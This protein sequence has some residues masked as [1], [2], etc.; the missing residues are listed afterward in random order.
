MTDAAVAGL[1]LPTSVPPAATNVSKVQ[2]PELDLA[3]PIESLQEQSSFLWKTLQKLGLDVLQFLPKLFFALLLLF[4][5]MRLINCI[6]RRIEVKLKQLRLEAK[7]TAQQSPSARKTSGL[8]PTLVGFVVSF[9]SNGL[10]CMLLVT[11]AGQMGISTTSMIAV[12]SMCSLAIGLAL[13]NLLKDLAS[14]VMVL[15]FK[16]FVVGD[17]VCFGTEKGKGISGWV[18][19]IAMFEVVIL[20]PDN[21]TIIVPHST[22]SV[23]TNYTTE[24]SIRVDV[25]LKISHSADVRLAQK[26]LLD[27]AAKHPSIIQEPKPQVHMKDVDDTGIVLIVRAFIP[28]GDYLTAPL[29]IRWE[30]KMTLEEASIPLARCW[31]FDYEHACR[32][33]SEALPSAPGPTLLTSRAKRNVVTADK[34]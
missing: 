15:L 6:T 7:K 21:K 30:A 28:S 3:H 1:Q 4:V 34:M 18:Q 12:F 11:A 10:K 13:Q 24:A 19:E 29:A 27:M 14:G 5:G 20:T 22:V 2:A 26:A 23:V 17:L 8:D 31:E 25:E 33:G 16:P 9:V 32:P